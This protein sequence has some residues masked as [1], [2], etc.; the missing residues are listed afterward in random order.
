MVD[1]PLPLGPT[2]AIVFPTSVLRLTWSRTCHGHTTV[3]VGTNKRNRW[4]MFVSETIHIEIQF[5][6]FV[7]GNTT[8]STNNCFTTIYYMSYSEV[9]VS[10][11]VR[12]Y[13]YVYEIVCVCVCVCACVLVCL[14]A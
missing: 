1:L 10:V 9:F 12:V 7:K 2:R 4:H 3:A 11:C 13:M 6:S 8:A 5:V 14:C